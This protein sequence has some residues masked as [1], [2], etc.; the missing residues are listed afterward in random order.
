MFFPTVCPMALERCA[1]QFI[2]VR[3][4]L[5]TNDKYLYTHFFVACVFVFFP[6][7]CILLSFVARASK[8]PTDRDAYKHNLANSASEYID[9]HMQRT[10]TTK[11]EELG[12]KEECC[13]TSLAPPWSNRAASA[14]EKKAFESSR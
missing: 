13:S 11:T 14:R 9:A 4:A 6:T 10:I 12:K 1:P 2:F 5:G 3:S 7:H 8:R